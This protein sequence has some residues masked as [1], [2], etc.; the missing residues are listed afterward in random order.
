MWVVSCKISSLKLKVV[1]K[2]IALKTMKT[3]EKQAAQLKCRSLVQFAYQF[4]TKLLTKLKFFNSRALMSNNVLTNFQVCIVIEAKIILIFSCVKILVPN[5]VIRPN[6]YLLPSLPL[7]PLLWISVL[8]S[9][10]LAQIKTKNL[11]F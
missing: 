2:Y 8:N 11:I 6:Y 9:V 5:P 4:Q 3:C 10:Y 1:K 7:Y